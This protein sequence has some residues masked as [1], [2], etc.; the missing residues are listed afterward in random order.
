MKQ[1]ESFM[2]KCNYSVELLETYK[3]NQMLIFYQ[4]HHLLQLALLN[5]QR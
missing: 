5:D 4:M 2:G 3:Y 1:V